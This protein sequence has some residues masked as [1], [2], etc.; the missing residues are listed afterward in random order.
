MENRDSG[1][2][3]VAHIPQVMPYACTA[4]PGSLGLLSF[5]AVCQESRIHP[6]A[7]GILHLS[8][9]GTRLLFHVCLVS[10]A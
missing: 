7:A 8:D 4:V 5:G 3:L 9:Q 2:S 10:S 1:G 6:S